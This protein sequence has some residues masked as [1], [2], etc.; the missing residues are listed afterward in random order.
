MSWV[1]FVWHVYTYAVYK[2]VHIC[3]AEDLVGTVIA[4]VAD[5][6]VNDLCEILA[7]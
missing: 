1:S 7:T 5:Q 4:G 3:L 2:A 6:P